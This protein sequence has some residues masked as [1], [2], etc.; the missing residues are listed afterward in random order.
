MSWAVKKKCKNA[1]QKLVLLFL[2]NH[3]NGRTGQCN[4][5]HKLLADEC[6]M[7][8]SSLKTQIRWLNDAGYI[9]IIKNSHNGV[10]L[11][12]QYQL[13]MDEIDK[14]GAFIRVGQILAT[15]H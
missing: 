9:S 8:I 7:S 15:K 12:N 5:S 11:P 4:P 14:S 6:C 1:S 13:L 3:T 10:S 2:A